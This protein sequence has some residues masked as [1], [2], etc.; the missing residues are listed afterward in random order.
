MCA[1]AEAQGTYQ[2]NG[3]TA[4]LLMLTYELAPEGLEANHHV[5]GQRLVGLKLHMLHIPYKL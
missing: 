1:F 2:C 3:N 5:C 4:S